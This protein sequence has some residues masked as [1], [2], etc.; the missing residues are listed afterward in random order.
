[1]VYR[2]SQDESDGVT[3]SIGQ[4]ARG[5]GGGGIHNGGTFTGTD[6][7]LD[8]NTTNGPGGGLFNEGTAYLIQGVL[9]N[10]MAAASTLPRGPPSW[11]R[12][13]LSP[14]ARRSMP[15][16][17]ARRRARTSGVWPVRRE[18]AVTS[19]P[20]RGARSPRRRP[21]SRRVRTAA[22]AWTTTA[23]GGP[24]TRIPPA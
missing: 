16:P 24:T 2:I 21:R 8:G 14:A 11:R 12:A 13:R 15:P 23:T 17:A 5:V 19:A 18:R 7:V 10:N 1:F 22:T 9:R 20:W 3:M 4:D 6:L